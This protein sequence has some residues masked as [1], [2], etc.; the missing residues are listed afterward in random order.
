M[1]ENAGPLR[2]D[3]VQIPAT[4][5]KATCLELMDRVQQSRE[6]IVITKHGKPI[7]RLVPLEE[8]IASL[9]GCMAGSVTILGDIVSPSMPEYEPPAFPAT[10]PG[11]FEMSGDDHEG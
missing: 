6:T 8:P 9:W 3:S 10:V 11:G 2:G 7:A 1:N 5:F 4:K